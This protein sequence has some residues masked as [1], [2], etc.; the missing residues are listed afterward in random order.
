M[1]VIDM[2]L[3]SVY[4]MLVKPSY[5]IVDYN[6]KC[7]RTISVASSVLKQYRSLCLCRFSGLTAESL[8]SVET[9]LEDVQRQLLGLFY[10]DTILVGHSLE[11]D[12]R[13]LK[14]GGC[15]WVWVGVCGSEG[16]WGCM[17]TSMGVGV[18]YV[19]GVGVC[20]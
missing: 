18:Y 3:Q 16:G 6:T 2:D 20:I 13:A 12:L 1:T 11:S 7:V 15:G 17:C 10:E 4:E 8:A 5:P 19:Q 14:V 9:R